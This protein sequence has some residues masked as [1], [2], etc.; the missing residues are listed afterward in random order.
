MTPST[1]RPEA[2]DTLSRGGRLCSGVIAGLGWTA[3]ALQ[4]AVSLD[5][6]MADGASVADVVWRYLGYFTILTNLLVAVTMTR[7]AGSGAA[8]VMTPSAP[9]TTGVV[10]AIAV[11][12][13]AYEVALRAIAPAMGPVWW[14]ADRLLHYV[15]P[16]STVVWWAVFVPRGALSHRHPRQWIVFPVAYLIYA[17]ARGA[18]DGWYPY[19][20]IDVGRLGYGRV[21][22]NAGVLTVALLGSGH[23]V[24]A[25]SQWLRSRR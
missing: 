6:M 25:A 11:V 24:V 12:G 2:V 19:F 7:L 8:R 9:A 20:L 3:L 4:L 23:V 13:I 1:D 10:L 18:I 22:I 5:L 15:V 16:L 21:L 14:T 17:L